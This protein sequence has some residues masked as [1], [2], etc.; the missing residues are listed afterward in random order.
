MEGDVRKKLADARV[1]ERIIGK[2]FTVWKPEPAEIVNRLGWLDIHR[3][4]A[5]GM[6]EIDAAVDAARSEGCNFALLIGM[7]GSSLAPEVFRKVFGVA[8][9]YLN[10][11]VLDSTDP[12]AILTHAAVIDFAKTLFVVSTKS[13]G[14]IETLS[15]MKYFYNLTAEKLGKD[16]AGNHFIAITDPG[17]SLEDAAKA[18]GFRHIFYGDPEIGGRFSAL[19]MFGL[20]PA[21]LLG[22]DIKRLLARVDETAAHTDGALLGGLLGELALQGRDK[23]TFVFSQRLASLGGWIEQLV[24]ESTGKEGKGILPVD[25][26]PWGAPHFYGA[27]RIFCSVRLQNDAIGEAHLR[28]MSSTGH[29][30]VDLTIE[31][32]GDL[33]ALFY[34]WEMATAV[35][36]WR[37]GLNPFDQPNVESAKMRARTMIERY[38]QDKA[39]PEDTPVAESSGFSVFG[40]V[41]VKEPDDVLGEFFSQAKASP[42]AYAAFM[43]YFAPSPWIDDALQRLRGVVV[44]RFSIATTFGYGPRF[45]HSTGQLHKGDAGRG[46]FVQFTADDREDAP[47]PDSMDSPDYEHEAS[48]SALTF[49]VLKKAQALGDAA[50]LADAGRKVIRI[51][52]RGNPDREIDRLTRAL[53]Q[54]T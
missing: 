48:L 12:G 34:F 21:R 32:V 31:E 29:P 30:V 46:L 4:M 36:G 25:V 28:T 13:G 14:T 15:L 39:L 5:S 1:V 43:A 9:G 37:M 18:H 45:L 24:A 49:G 23:L 40:N 35:A 7:G 22:I 20:A 10:L 11:E 51:H 42:P 33:G 54:K 52:F 38:L 47:V 8:E 50:A 19:S 27:D 2:D 16:K 3:R 53:A 6:E 44:E 17:S 41:A 26:E